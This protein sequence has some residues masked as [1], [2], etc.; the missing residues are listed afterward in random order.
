M[1]GSRRAVEKEILLSTIKKSKETV[2]R[3]WKVSILCLTV[4]VF[5]HLFLVHQAVVE[6]SL[7]EVEISVLRT[8][9]TSGNCFYKKSHSNK[10]VFLSGEE[11]L[12]AGSEIQTDIASQAT[13][14]FVGQSGRL[15]L[16]SQTHMEVSRDNSYMLLDF[17]KGEAYINYQGG[18]AHRPLRVKIDNKVFQ[19]TN[20]D[21][22]ITG[23]I[24]DQVQVSVEYGKLTMNIGEQ[25]SSFE[26]GQ[27]IVFKNDREYAVEEAK[28]QLSTPFNYDRYNLQEKEYRV[29]FG[30]SPIAED[31]KLQLLVGPSPQRLSPHFNE[32]QRFDQNEF[33]LPFKKGVYYWQLAG[34]KDGERVF[35]DPIKKFFVEPQ[36]PIQL[37]SPLSSSK[38]QILRDEA[39]VQFQWDNPSQ[40]E[41]VFLEISEQQD[42][43]KTLVNESIPENNYFN[44]KFHKAG[45]YYWRVS[46]FPYGTTELVSSQPSKVVIIDEVIPQQVKILFPKENTTLTTLSLKNSDITFQWTKSPLKTEY[47]V[48]ITSRESGKKLVFET[49][50]NQLK[51]KDLE[52]G[53]YEWKVS[54]KESNVVSQTESF[55]VVL[56][57]RLSFTK[58]SD[59]NGYLSW[60]A[61]PR[62][63]V[64]YR[65]E[66]LRIGS[67]SDFNAFFDPKSST[68]RSLEISGDRISYKNFSEGIYAFKVYALDSNKNILAD[69]NL[70]FLNVR[71]KD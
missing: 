10:W 29:R 7:P 23:D 5:V 11:I 12:T 70:R 50:E 24:E 21:I 17:K 35:L 59:E 68:K 52:Q 14:S 6:K 63:T 2:L 15:E 51:V 47:S 66:A 42:F 71:K 16:A 4:L 58:E 32:P 39:I 20:A 31:I 43:S 44:Y 1:I 3:H 26:K 41:K 34:Y 37:V 38:H 36:I 25:V 56:T 61:G 67:R 69:S 30:F 57:R 65:V 54:D 45:E 49:Q 40:L 27:Y 18:R 28:V 8:F 48:E 55:K 19:L 33:S 46:G 13:L 62:G 22:Y 64:Q 9:K 53:Q 60:Q